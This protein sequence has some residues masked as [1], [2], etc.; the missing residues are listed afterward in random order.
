[1]N[2][3]YK[4]IVNTNPRQIFSA[5]CLSVFFF[6][7]AANAQTPPL[8]ANGKIAFTS[9]RDGNREIYM[10]NNDG[11]GQVRLTNNPGADNPPGGPS[12]EERAKGKTYLWG[13]ASDLNG[14]RVE[15]R[16]QTPEGYTI[17]ALAALNIAQKILEGNFKPGFQTPAKAYG[18]DLVLE[19]EGVERQ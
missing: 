13:E 1:M 2:A 14:N 10:M 15:S 11:T 18:A 9:D 17:T 5:V 12:D 19:I 4:S 3:N 7:A 8:R 6:V 16:L